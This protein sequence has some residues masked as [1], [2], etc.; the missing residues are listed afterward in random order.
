M[1]PF[2]PSAEIQL[3]GPLCSVQDW[4]DD[5][6]RGRLEGLREHNGKKTLCLRD[7]KNCI[8]MLRNVFILH[9]GGIYALTVGLKG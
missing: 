2:E 6:G 5:K 1:P 8:Q 3:S 9:A 4:R 7:K